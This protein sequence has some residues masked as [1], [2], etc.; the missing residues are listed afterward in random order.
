MDSVWIAMAYILAVFI[1]EKPVDEQGNV[2]EPSGEYSPGLLMSVHLPS[3]SAHC[4][5][6]FFRLIAT[7]SHSRRCLSPG[8]QLLLSSCS[9]LR[10]S[11]SL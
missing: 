11:T 6:A 8:L 4:V 10:S 5:N 2:V 3:C 1:I 7:R 9:P